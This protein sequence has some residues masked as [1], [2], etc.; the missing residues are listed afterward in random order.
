MSEPAPEA[1]NT[2]FSAQQEVTNALDQANN[3]AEPTA[4]D[5]YAPVDNSAYQEDVPWGAVIEGFPGE[6]QA[7]LNERLQAYTDEITQPYQGYEFLQEAEVDPDTVQYAL[8]MLYTLNSN[9]RQLYDAIAEYYQFGGGQPQAPQG[10]SDFEYGEEASQ[11]DPRY[12][13]LEEKLQM[14]ARALVEQQ[15]TASAAEEDQALEDELSGLRE[16]YGDFDEEFVLG[17]ALSDVPLEQGVQR[18]KQLTGQVQQQQRPQSPVVMGS[19]GGV[20]GQQPVNPSKLSS[21]DTKN[22]VVQMLQSANRE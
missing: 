6:T 4:T 20:P 18:F 22:L 1:P 8:N 12:A 10:T 14:V 17:L 7:Q 2:V 19:G 3:T 9:P 13:E 11:D 15:Q 5:S 21:S 16:K